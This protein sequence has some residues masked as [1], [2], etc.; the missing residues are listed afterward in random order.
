M[1]TINNILAAF[2][3]LIAIGAL[4]GVIFFGATHQLFVFAVATAMA[5]TTIADNKK[6]ATV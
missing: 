1:K 6:K 3:A 2:F 5:I 4:I